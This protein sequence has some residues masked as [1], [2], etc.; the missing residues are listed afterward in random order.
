M[1]TRRTL[2]GLAGVA[3]AGFATH[4]LWPRRLSRNFTGL[5]E[6]VAVGGYDPVAYFTGGAPAA[7]RDDITASHE[8][9]TWRF[10]TPENRVLFL[11]EPGRYAPQY[12]G[13]CAYAVAGGGT[14][15]G[16]PRYWSIV[17]GRLFLNASRRVHEKWRADAT[18]YIAKA[19]AN[20]PRVLGN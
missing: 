18:G 15:P 17:E 19:D 1:L 2:V 12:G 14:A 13:Y 10:A 5:V 7:G 16:V 8:D 4:Q 3:A 9:V 11:A 20:W 6:G